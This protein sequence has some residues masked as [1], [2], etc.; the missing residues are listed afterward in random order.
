M[1]YEM[2]TLLI[3]DDEELICRGLLRQ[4][5][6]RFD[7]VYFAT[8]PGDAERI[9][10]DIEVTD[11]ICDYNLGENVPPGTELLHEWRRAYPNIRRAVI[12]SGTDLSCVSIP[13]TVDSAVSKTA[14]IDVLFA[15][16][17]PEYAQ[18]KTSEA[19]GMENRK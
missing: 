13:R 4:F 11:L 19:V 14:S 15:A 7:R 1:S 2:N 3:V 18:K 9:L 17:I 10:A 12:F 8:H 6:G 5:R 16:L